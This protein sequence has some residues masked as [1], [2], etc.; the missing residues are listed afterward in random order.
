MEVDGRMEIRT[1]FKFPVKFIK[2]TIGER[3]LETTSKGS[4]CNNQ[5][6]AFN[7]LIP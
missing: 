4:S 7:N 3:V 1:D 6:D 2:T 5:E